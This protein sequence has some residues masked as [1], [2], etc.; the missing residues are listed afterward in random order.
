MFLDSIYYFAG[1]KWLDSMTTNPIVH[2]TG[3]NFYNIHGKYL[4]PFGEG[5]YVIHGTEEE[6]LITM[7]TRGGSEMYHHPQYHY[8]G[9]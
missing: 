8:Y 1:L 9:A 2:I 6:P 7:N 5:S 4:L 3:G